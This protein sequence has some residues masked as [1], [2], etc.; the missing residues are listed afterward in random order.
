MTSKFSL[1]FT[2]L[3]GQIDSVAKKT[4]SDDVAYWKPTK[5]SAGNATALIRFLPSKNI[6]DFPFVRLYSHSFQDPITKRWYFEN[7]LTTIG[8]Q[9]MISDVNK[10]LWNSGIEENKK[11]AQHRKRKLSYIVNIYVIKDVGNPENDGKVFKYKFGPKI[12]DKIVNASKGDVELG[13]EPILAFCPTNGADFLLKMQ[14]ANDQ[15]NY[16]A[17]KFNAKKPFMNGDDDAIGAILAQ[18][19]DIQLEVGPDKF[20]SA[21]ELAKK[22]L[23]VIGQDKPATDAAV[24][25]EMDM[26]AKLATQTAPKTAPAKQVEQKVEEDKPAEQKAAKKTPPMPAME[27]STDSDEDFFKS[28]ME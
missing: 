8:Q 9:D 2:K 6:D 21:D 17:S 13:E 24:N 23:W 7:S 27:P 12:W 25:A 18:C 5:D 26:L 22:F 19:F 1:D 4:Y 3:L 15:Y 16:D 14:K 11:I 10:E 20:K 28:L